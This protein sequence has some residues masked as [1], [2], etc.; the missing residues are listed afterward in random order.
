MVGDLIAAFGLVISLAAL[1]VGLA[2]AY[3]WLRAAWPVFWRMRGP[4]VVTCPET[5]RSAGVCVD[6]GHAA[7]TAFHAHPELRL[8]ACSRW[9]EKLDCGQDCLRQIEAA[10]EDCLVR[11]RLTRFYEGKRCAYCARAFGAIHWHD[12]RPALLEPDGRT[13]EWRE[14]APE[15]VPAALAAGKPVCWNCHVA[16]TFRREHPDLV[17]DRPWTE[18]ERHPR[19][20]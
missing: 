8:R 15:Q 3:Y 5:G 17:T 19:T 14:L 16:E 13:V 12:H 9:P 4:R 10:P 11:T 7:T 20:H 2:T 6:A 1:I 18:V